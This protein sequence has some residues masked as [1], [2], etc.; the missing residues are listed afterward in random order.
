ME[1]KNGNKMFDQLEGNVSE[2]KEKHSSCKLPHQLFNPERKKPL[3]IVI[4]LTLMPRIHTEVCFLH[5]KGLSVMIL[6]E[7]KKKGLVKRKGFLKFAI[8]F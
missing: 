1:E 8:N 2:Y 3:I 5:L 6:N 4:V 7:I